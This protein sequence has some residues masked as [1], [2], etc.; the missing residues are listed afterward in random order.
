MAEK[1]ETII[2]G[3][4]QAGLA[5][6]YYLCEAGKEHLI[7]EKGA[8]A[9]PVW[10]QE[11]WDSFTL[12]TPNWAVRLPGAEYRG[13]YPDSFMP[14]REIATYFQRYAAE[15]QLPLQY[16]TEVLS[17]DQDPSGKGYRVKT[18]NAEYEALNVVIA[19]GLFQKP[20]IP[21][22]SSNL[23]ERILQLP[24]GRYRN[25]QSL[26]AGAVLVVGSAQSGGQI[27]EE[28]YQ[29]GRTVYLCVG[30]AGRS[31]RRYRGQDIWKWLELTGFLNR[32]V[33]QLPF[34]KA[35]FVAPPHLS[36]AKGG[37]T[38]NL[39]QFARDGVVLLGHLQDAADGKIMLAPD[40]MDNLARAD[41]FEADQVKL[42]DAFIE[43]SGITAPQ[44]TLPGL[45]DGYEARVI[46]EL[47]L[48]A[49]GITSVIWA[50]GYTFDFGWAKPARLDADGYPVQQRGVTDCPGLYF[51]GLP[52]MSTL[53]SAM[54]MGVGEHAAYIA[55]Q[56]AAQPRA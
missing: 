6:S 42:I 33:D 52:W 15:F 50:T 28:L 26:P 5:T 23:P 13:A 56:L 38:I 19:T 3:G 10:Q 53:K 4:G 27:A 43:R 55:S 31:P 35:K 1:V 51:V 2:I 18:R 54:L 21:A 11:R 7:L 48:Q 39:H 16:N 36:G 29:N 47:D 49:A 32:T 44:E 45:R 46:S 22:F 34:P 40:L 12:V 20:K 24:S 41:K 37:H 17:V 14:R 8:Q 25:P 9:A 30:S